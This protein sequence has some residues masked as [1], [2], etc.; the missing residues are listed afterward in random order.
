[1]K[2][3]IRI[4]ASIVACVLMM[5]TLTLNVMAESITYTVGDATLI[6]SWTK[7][8]TKATVGVFTDKPEVNTYMTISGIYYVNGTTAV[9]SISNDNNGALYNEI[10]ISSGGGPWVSLNAVISATYGSES[11]KITLQL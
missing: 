2:K 4:T 1:M 6:V 8:P 7:T 3:L 10:T 9:K 5:S 11:N